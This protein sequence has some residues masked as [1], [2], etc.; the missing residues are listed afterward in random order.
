MI[1]VQRPQ[2]V[3]G[4]SGKMIHL[5]MV[6]QSFA[7]FKFVVAKVYSLDKVQMF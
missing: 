5:G 1:F 3:N 4:G 7:V 2:K 6:D